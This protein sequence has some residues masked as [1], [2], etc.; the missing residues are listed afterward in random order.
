MVSQPCRMY[1]YVDWKVDNNCLRFA[2]R[3]RNFIE[4]IVEDSYR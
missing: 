3:Y 1:N 4:V 2:D